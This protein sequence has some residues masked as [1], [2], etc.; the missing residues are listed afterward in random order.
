[1]ML[2]ADYRARNNLTLEAM[3]AD[4]GVTAST[5]AKWER[6]S[7]FPRPEQIDAIRRA[8]KGSVTAD[9]LLASY[10]SARKGRS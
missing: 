5:I 10:R 6:G 4:C 8:T 3:A 7:V 9:D 2:L 1:M